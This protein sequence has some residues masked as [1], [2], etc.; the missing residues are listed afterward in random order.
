MLAD[1]VGIQPPP[2]PPSL[3]N[4]NNKI[5]Y[6]LVNV[7]F[8]PHIGPHKPCG[9]KLYVQRPRARAIVSLSVNM[10]LAPARDLGVYACFA[11][12]PRATLASCCNRARARHCALLRSGMP[13]ACVRELSICAE[14][15]VYA[16]A[17][18][19]YKVLTLNVTE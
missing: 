3:E 13:R 8:R 9:F 18:A 14:L 19:Q 4:N 17:R 7:F 6:L 11:S 10:P 12:R 15:G 16:C 2:P 5:N 1:G